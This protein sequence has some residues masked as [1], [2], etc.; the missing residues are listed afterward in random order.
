MFRF[1]FFGFVSDQSRLAY[2]A[3]APAR[4]KIGEGGCRN[5]ADGDY[6]VVHVESLAYPKK[7]FLKISATHEQ[8]VSVDNKQLFVHSRTS[9]LYLVPNIHG[10][11]A[12]GYSLFDHIVHQRFRQT[13]RARVTID[14]DSHGY[15]ARGGT[16]QGC[17]HLARCVVISNLKV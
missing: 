4:F 10:S 7:V 15:A 14:E 9:Q 6:I 8:V 17:K 5:R 12:N 13:I 2:V 11:F 1:R 16:D 3:F